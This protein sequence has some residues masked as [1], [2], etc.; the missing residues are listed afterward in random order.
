MRCKRYIAILVG[1]WLLGCAH[2]DTVTQQPLGTRAPAFAQYVVA[3]HRQIHKVFTLGFLADIDARKDP[4]YADQ[5]LWTQVSIAVD[6]DGRI[7]RVGVLRSSGLQAFDAAVVESLRAAAPFPPPPDSI[8]S[9]DGKVHLD[10]QFHRDERSC[11][12]FG[13]DPHLYGTAS[14]DVAPDQG[15]AAL[16]AVQGWFA[17][18][19][20]GAGAWLAGWS[21]TPFLADGQVIARD[22]A[23]LETFYAEM[24]KPIADNTIAEMKLLTPAEMRSATGKLPTGGESDMLFATGR[25]GGKAITLLLRKSSQGWR[26]CGLDR[27]L[28]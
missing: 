8:K 7:D 10:W 27:E 4:V 28:P 19:V 1:V 23:T 2:H 21:A 11:G 16:I 17:A 26:V 14:N 5:A 3:M 25:V 20:R 24:A 15:S 6:A 9:A 22:G 13:V 18:Y 12:A